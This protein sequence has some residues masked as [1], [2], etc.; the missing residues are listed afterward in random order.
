M[1][2]ASDFYNSGDNDFTVYNNY[3]TKM[4]CYGDTLVSK[5]CVVLTFLCY[6]YTGCHCNI[7]L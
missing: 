3:T 5:V 2:R 4:E 7:R 6:I 1:S